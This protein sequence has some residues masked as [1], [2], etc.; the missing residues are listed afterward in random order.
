MKHQ[1]IQPNSKPCSPLLPP[2]RTDLP[3]VAESRSWHCNF[4]NCSSLWRARRVSAR[5]LADSEAPLPDCLVANSANS[6]CGSLW[7]RCRPTN[8]A[9]GRWLTRWTTLTYAAA[10][11]L[12][13]V[14][15]VYLWWTPKCDVFLFFFARHATLWELRS[16]HWNRNMN[17]PFAHDRALFGHAPHAIWDK[18]HQMPLMPRHFQNEYHIHGRRVKIDRPWKSMMSIFI[19]KMPRPLPCRNF[20]SFLSLFSLEY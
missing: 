5:P 11:F 3:G 18:G 8:R 1:I 7:P 9:P 4:A 20:K 16:F 2:T 10:L 19:L 15:I 14:M 17:V 13:C 6:T 12:F